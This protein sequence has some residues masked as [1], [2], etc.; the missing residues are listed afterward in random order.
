MI[1]FSLPRSILVQKSLTRRP[2]ST[3][4][5]RLGKKYRLT[6]KTAV[7]MV[8]DL[9]QDDRD[10]LMEALKQRDEKQIGESGAV[11][12]PGWSDLNKLAFHQSIPFIGFGFLDNLIM[13]VAG[14]YIDQTI[15]ASLCIR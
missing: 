8:K 4:G 5:A 10:L 15:G 2:L 13:I 12:K 1:P 3:T 11:Q 6:P 7:K 9:N 14:E